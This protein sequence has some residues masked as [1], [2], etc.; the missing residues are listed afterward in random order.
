M[1]FFSITIAISIFAFFILMW[2]SFFV[3]EIQDYIRK[4]S[5]Y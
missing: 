5:F 2:T 4:I 3:I 1:D